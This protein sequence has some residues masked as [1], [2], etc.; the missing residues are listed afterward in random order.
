MRAAGAC[1]AGAALVLGTDSVNAP[2]HSCRLNY[3][4]N[5]AGQYECPVLNKA[6]GGL[7]AAPNSTALTRL[8]LAPGCSL[9]RAAGGGQL[10]ARAAALHADIALLCGCRCSPSTRTSALWQAPNC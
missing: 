1:A 6:R 9:C 7:S 10:R 2:L 4:K 8:L 3:H 5:D